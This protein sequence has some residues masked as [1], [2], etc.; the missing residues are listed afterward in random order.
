MPLGALEDVVVRDRRRGWAGL[1]QPLQSLPG[2]LHVGDEC[3]NDGL[4]CERYHVSGASKL[5]S[6]W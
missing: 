3:V 1:V 4:H 2:F 5:P 6:L